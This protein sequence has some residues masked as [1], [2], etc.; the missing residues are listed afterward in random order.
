MKLA[1][2]AGIAGGLYIYIQ[3]KLEKEKKKTE[4]FKAYY[5]VLCRWIADH[6]E[7]KDLKE[8]FEINNYQTVAIYGRGILGELLYHELKEMNIEVKYFIDVNCDM[9]LNIDNIPIIDVD[10]LGE[11][12]RVDVVIITPI[13]ALE[14]ISEKIRETDP[15]ININSIDDIF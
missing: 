11:Q 4:K 13:F 7:K 12:E 3:K 2:V 10:E 6:H 1:A 15:S 8:F 9:Y 5:N 14:D